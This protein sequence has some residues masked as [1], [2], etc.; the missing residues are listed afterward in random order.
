M[1]VQPRKV[2]FMAKK[3]LNENMRFRTFLKCNADGEELDKQF[4]HLHNELFEN[5][6][7]NGCR[8]CC[9]QYYGS[10]PAGEITRDAGYLNMEV[11]EFIDTYLVNEKAEENYR[12]KH[13]PCDFLEEN[14]VCKLGECKPESCEKFPYTN[15]PGRM[16]SLYSVLDAVEVCPVAFEIFERLKQEYHFLDE[17]M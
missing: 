1:M 12:T 13:K 2:K 5:Y 9:K 3:K 16:E 7:C 6:D 8:N 15:K 4:L 17:G 11:S 10:I 14:G